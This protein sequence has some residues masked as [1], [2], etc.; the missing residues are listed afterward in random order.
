MSIGANIQAVRKDMEGAAVR[1]GRSPED[2][3]LVAVTKLHSPEEINEAIDAGVTDIG[4]NKVQEVLAKYDKVKPV[5]WHLI[6]HLQTN[7]V[8]QIVDKVVMIHSVDSLHLAEEINKRCASIGKNMDILV[9]VNVAEEDSKFGITSDETMSL[10][11]AIADTCPNV[12][13]KGLMMIA[14]FFDDPEMTRPYFR[15]AKKL[16][17]DCADMPARAGVDMKY[18]S[19]G[20][21]NDFQIAVEEGSNLIRVGTAIFGNRNYRSEEK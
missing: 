11:S 20:M 17:D 13:V 4:E 2:V 15:M 14:P 6:G 7:K 21:T 18:L 3:L 9:Q 12:T 16:F 1:S 10:I 5:R 8:R 19:M